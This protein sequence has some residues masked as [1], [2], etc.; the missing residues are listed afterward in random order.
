M[1]NYQKIYNR[2]VKE[3]KKELDNHYNDNSS[4]DLQQQLE[5][6][7]GITV[8][9]WILSTLDEI[10]GKECHMVIMNEKQFKQWQKKIK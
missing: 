6:N 9:E 2:L 5:N 7:Y 1:K 3:I 8:L 4:Y 10:E